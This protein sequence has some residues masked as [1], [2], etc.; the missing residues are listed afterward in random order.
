MAA[1]GKVTPR[2]I[3]PPEAPLQLKADLVSKFKPVAIAHLA[4]GPNVFAIQQYTALTSEEIQDILSLESYQAYLKN[5]RP[6]DV[7]PS[8]AEIYALLRVQATHGDNSA[9]K[10]KAIIELLKY[11]PEGREDS[12]LKKYAKV[13]E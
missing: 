10:Q 9:S 7:L 3:D 8:R 12:I 1:F 5:I 4:H 6:T 13:A 11:V 2:L